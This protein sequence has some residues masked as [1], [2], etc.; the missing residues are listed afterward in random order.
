ML[1]YLSCV[2]SQRDMSSLNLM[3]FLNILEAFSS[4]EVFHR[5][6]PFPVKLEAPSNKLLANFKFLG[7]HRD[8]SPSNFTAFL[9]IANAPLTLLTSQPEMSP[10]KR[11]WPSKSFTMFV[12]ELT[13]QAEML[14]SSGS[15]PPPKRL[16]RLVIALTSQSEILQYTR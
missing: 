4:L 12:T 2:T 6:K 7:F 5:R 15:C 11:P 3:A 16:L 13:S 8:R 9:N 10:L 1:K 14:T